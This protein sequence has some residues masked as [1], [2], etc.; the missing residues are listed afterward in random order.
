MM[1][2]AKRYHIQRL[3]IV[4]VMQACG[5]QCAVEYGALKFSSWPVFF[6]SITACIKLVFVSL[7]IKS[8][9]FLSVTH[10][11]IG[12]S[13]ANTVKMITIS[14]TYTFMKFDKWLIDLT[15]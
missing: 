11:S 3:V 14:V 9:R 10:F 12:A 7:I 5:P 1:V 13:T 15:F 6:N 2:F 4:D 8:A